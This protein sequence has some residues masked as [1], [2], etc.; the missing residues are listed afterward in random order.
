MKEEEII[1]RWKKEKIKT[2]TE[3][4]A[5]LLQTGKKL[6]IRYQKIKFE[7]AYKSIYYIKFTK[8]KSYE[9]LRQ[10]EELNSILFTIII[11]NIIKKTRHKTNK[12]YKSITKT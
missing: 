1:N 11:D 3:K 12:K 10:D 6:L 9:G 5:L 2:K 4:R 7:K 8:F